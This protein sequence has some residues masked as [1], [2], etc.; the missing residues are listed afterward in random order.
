MHFSCSKRA[1]RG[2]GVQFMVK[3]RAQLVFIV[4][5]QLVVEAGAQLEVRTHMCV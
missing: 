3:A 5:V 1:D 4:C 2:Q